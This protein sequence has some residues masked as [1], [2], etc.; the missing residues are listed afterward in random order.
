MNLRTDP[1]CFFLTHLVPALQ[2]ITK[3][4][5]SVDSDMFPI[6][7]KAANTQLAE[8]LQAAMEGALLSLE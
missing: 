8:E 7:V 6:Q 1:M 2:S 3:I 4:V 5:F